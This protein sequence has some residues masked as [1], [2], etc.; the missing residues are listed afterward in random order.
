MKRQD[1]QNLSYEELGHYLSKKGELVFRAEQIFDWIYKKG[2]TDFE[3]MKNLSAALRR[4]LKDDF[5]FSPLA[6]EPFISSD[7]TKKFLFELHDHEKIE[8]VVIPTPKRATVCVS[9][10]VG[11]KFGCKFCASGLGG[12]KRNLDCSE[13]LSQIIFVKKNNGAKP[14]THIVFM[15]VGEPLDNYENVLKAIRIINSK[16]GMNIGARRIT[17]STCGLIPQ[18][19]RLIQEKL[20]VELAVSLHGHNDKSRKRLMPISQ[21]YPIQELITACREYTQTTK[22]QI[23]FEYILVKGET[24]SDE[25]AKEL[26]RLLKGLICKLNLIPYNNVAE[27]SCETPTRKEVAAF[28]HSLDKYGVH[29]TV[30]TPRG[31]DVSAACGQLRHSAE[32]S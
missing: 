22:R 26:G 12:W 5:F 31:Q 28:K 8:T 10:Q 24:C 19:K 11:C 27:F 17:I 29:A 1:I 2:V 20:Q 3:E 4:R 21:K 6:I 32:R 18:M 23:T 30:R 25:A 15:G 7:G 13:I 9:T 14:L 16:E